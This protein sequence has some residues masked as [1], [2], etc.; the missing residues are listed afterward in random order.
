VN[1][2]PVFFFSYRTK[3]SNVFFKFCWLIPFF[4]LFFSACTTTKNVAYFQDLTDT[5]KI[6]TQAINGT[7]EL[8]IQPDDILK[9]VVNNIYP[10]AAAPFNL[11]NSSSPL[12]ATSTQTIPGATGAVSPINTSGE[13]SEGYLVDKDGSI[14]FPI[15]GNI[16]VEGLT[17]NQLKDTLKPRL[18][19]YLQDPIINVRLLNYKVTVLGEVLHPST[20]SI[21]SERITV[22]DAIGMAGDLTIYGKRENVLLIREVNGQRKFI[23]LNLNSSNIFKSPY[24]YLKQNDIIYVEPNKSKIAASDVTQIRNISL[25]SAALT[26]LVVIITRF[27]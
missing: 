12:S 22:V 19:K 1:L 15:L 7:Y 13:S 3:S 16:K 21:P 10:E 23:R 4:F 20:Y 5:S 24:Y 18:S 6:Y 26:L 9:I 17:I 27:R 11:G 14:D 25:I 8:Q 2:K